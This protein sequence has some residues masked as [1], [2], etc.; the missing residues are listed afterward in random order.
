MHNLLTLGM[1]CFDGK[2]DIVSKGVDCACGANPIR[3]NRRFGT[4]EFG[5]D[6]CSEMAGKCGVHE[7]LINHADDL[8]T[9][10][11]YLKNAPENDKSAEIRQSEKFLAEILEDVSVAQSRNPCLTVGDLMIALESVG[12]PTFYTLNGAESLFFCVALRQVLV[13]RPIDP[14]KTDTVWNFDDDEDRPKF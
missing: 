7:Y 4:Y 9:I 2:V 11:E 13:I 14:A 10:R 8:T 3:E 1:D 5:T 6:K 12:I